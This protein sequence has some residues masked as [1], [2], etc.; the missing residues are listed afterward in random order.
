MVKVIKNKE[1]F[2]IVTAKKSLV[3]WQVL[4]D[5]LP[6]WLMA[7]FQVLRLELSKMKF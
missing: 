4:S 1:V 6:N 7:Q 5:E 2:E 3:G